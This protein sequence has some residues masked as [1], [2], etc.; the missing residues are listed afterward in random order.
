MPRIRFATATLLAVAALPAHGQPPHKRF[1]GGPVTLE[2]QGSFFVGGVTKIS[3]YAAVPGAPPGQPAPPRTPQQITIGQM[4]VQFQIPARLSRPGLAR[5]HGA[6]LDA[7]GRRARIDARRPRGLVSVFRA[8]GRR[9]LCRRSIGPRPFGVRSVGVERSRSATA[10]RQSRRS[11]RAAAD[12]AT[13]HR[14][15][16]VSG[17]VRPPAAGRR[18]DRHGPARFRTARPRIRR[19]QARPTSRTSRRSFR[20][21]TS[22]STTS[23]SCRTP[24]RRCPA[25]PA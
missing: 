7:H 25:R 1:M 13:H 12:V 9:D 19:A 11:G 14:Q 20:S 4:Y 6:R 18:D 16:R 23:S 22:P 8:Q 15:R 17:L 24:K 5:H 21:R 10:R 3:E 2:D